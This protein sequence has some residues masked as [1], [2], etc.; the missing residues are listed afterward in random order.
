MLRAFLE[1]KKYLK[2][3]PKMSFYLMTQETIEFIT[4]QQKKNKKKT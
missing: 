4:K 2:H 3:L 1:I